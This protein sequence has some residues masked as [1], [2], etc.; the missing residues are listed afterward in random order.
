VEERRLTIGVTGATG[1]IGNCFVQFLTQTGIA[2]VR[3]L[4]R[5]TPQYEHPDLRFIYGSLFDFP[6]LE[7]LVIQSDVIVHLAAINPTNSK[8]DREETGLFFATNRCGSKALSHLAQKHGKR[9]IHAS[10][11]AAY[12]LSKR[13]D[14]LFHEQ[15]PL[16]GRIKTQ[17]WFFSAMKRIEELEAQW[18]SGR[19][20]GILAAINDLLVSYPPPERES[21]YA[22]SKYMGEYPVVSYSE[23]YMLRFSDVYGPGDESSRLIPDVIRAILEGK[24]VSISFG[25]RERVSFVYIWDV[26]KALV[27]SATARDMPNIPVALNPNL[28]KIINVASTYAVNEKEFIHELKRISREAG[29]PTRITTGRRTQKESSRSFSTNA[30]EYE[31]GIVNPVS[32]HE[33]LALTL[34]YFQLSPEK[35]RIISL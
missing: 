7:E 25:P 22:L 15:E 3:A 8:I 31:L 1:A 27:L 33:G 17:A 2:E 4:L 34:R 11:V 13:T 29:V 5:K 16:P 23:G 24:E 30:M 6:S 9:L 32:L 14:G 12:E 10:T 28:P 18:M 35:R 26:V 19:L 20:Q 21:V